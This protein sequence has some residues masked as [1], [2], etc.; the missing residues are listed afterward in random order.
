MWHTGHDRAGL[1][2]FAIKN[3]FLSP[4]CQERFDPGDNID[5]DTKTVE[6][7]QEPSVINFIKGL[8]EV[9]NNNV[10]LSTFI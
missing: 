8:A 9:H 3:Y 2:L 5:I 4:V 7:Q 1:R 6:V 10:S